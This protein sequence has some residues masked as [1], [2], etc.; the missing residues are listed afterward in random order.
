LA[1]SKIEIIHKLSLKNLEF[2]EVLKIISN[3]TTSQLSSQKILSLYPTKNYLTLKN[4]Y[5]LI[6]SLKLF[7]ESGKNLGIGG[8]KFISEK[9]E[10]IN[11]RKNSHL[12][13]QEL[14]QFSEFFKNGK[15]IKKELKEFLKGKNFEEL[16]R[17]VSQIPD[18]M[19]ISKKIEEKISKNGEIREDKFP[20]LKNIRQ[21]ILELKGKIKNSYEKILLNAQKNNIAADG[22]ITI[23]N[24]RF[25]IPIK[26]GGSGKIRGIVHATS[27][28]GST[29]FI[30]PEKLVPLN[31][32]LLTLIEREREIIEK[33]LKDL[34]DLIRNRLEEVKLLLDILVKLDTHMAIAIYS[35]EYKCTEPEIS[36]DT[37]K[38][39]LE[40]GRHPILEYHHRKKGKKVVPISMELGEDG[41]CLIISGPNTGGK[42]ASLKTAGILS[43]M[44]LSG[45]FVPAEDF[46]LPMFKRI[47]AYIGDNQ[48]IEDDLSTFSS[49]INFMREILKDI[50]RPSLI[51]IDEAGSTTSHEEG[52]ALVI[53]MVEELI[54]RG[55]F[56]ILTTHN[57]HLKHFAITSPI[58]KSASVEFDMETLTPKYR[59]IPDS[60]GTSNAILIAEK[61]GLPKKIV[62]RANAI[63]EEFSG[64]PEKLLKKINDLLLEKE[65][66]LKEVKKIKNEEIIKKIKLEREIEEKKRNLREELSKKLKEFE[67]DF[68][69]EREKFF[70]NISEEIKNEKLKL[71]K[72]KGEK[73]FEKFLEKL[74]IEKNP[75][76]ELAPFD[77]QRAYIG[78]P[79]YSKD[80][81][82]EGNLIK[83]EKKM[84]TLQM[85][86]LKVKLPIKNLLMKKSKEVSQDKRENMEIEIPE[87]KNFI[88]EIDVRGERVLDAIEKIEKFLDDA[89]LRG[90]E[91]VAIIHGIGTGAL[92]KGI[93]K[94]LKEQPFVKGIHH[95]P[96]S[97]GGEGKTIVEL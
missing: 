26:A 12:T 62:E 25:V 43:L 58:C 60:A 55:A 69:R 14:I 32:K 17:L 23:R 3:Y 9:S 75:E 79:L 85:G 48:S 52:A 2:E 45:I 51:L 22:F 13:P 72:R 70:K 37:N 34:T 61:L 28:S 27:S 67:K 42:T 38:F 78:M 82:K 88:R 15:R 89:L 8:A 36:R 68:E 56:L 18:L 76:E 71:A 80:L 46:K 6:S 91:K 29:F 54:Q 65:M 11:F 30:E 92:K 41:R 40:E 64:K 44:A 74:E 19:D 66:E 94:Y 50:S 33:L 1:G 97:E 31:N 83:V 59:L 35:S 84:A 87:K 10:E 16:K 93:E 95:P 39:Y 21:E 53:A 57:S 7:Y 49:Y 63:R 24:N 90:E 96:R 47:F 5:E 4:T 73:I 20:P 81:K 86:D 77:P